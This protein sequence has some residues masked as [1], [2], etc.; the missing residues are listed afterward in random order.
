ML[1]P[2]G[3]EEGGLSGIGWANDCPM[4]LLCMGPGF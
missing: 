3:F 1:A 4:L 2:D